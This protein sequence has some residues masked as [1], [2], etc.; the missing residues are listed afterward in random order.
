MFIYAWS[1]CAIKFSILALYRRIFGM[2]YLGWFCVF[3][4]TGYLIATHIVLL[5]YSRPI[6][7]YWNKWYGSQGE[8]LVDEAKVSRRS[9]SH[10]RMR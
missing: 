3:L 5:L 7:H 2:S 1:V 9:L 8:C 6:S 4:T 10:C